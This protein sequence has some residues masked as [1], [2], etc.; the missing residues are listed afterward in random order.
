MAEG[1]L[2]VVVRVDRLKQDGGQDLGRSLGTAIR[3]DAD[4]ARVQAPRALEGLELPVLPVDQAAQL[5]HGEQ[6]RH[7]VGGLRGTSRDAA[8]IDQ[9]GVAGVA[10]EQRLHLRGRAGAEARDPQHAGTVDLFEVRLQ[11]LVLFQGQAHVDAV[12]APHQLQVQFGTD[13]AGELTP[14]LPQRHRA[15]RA[16]VDTGDDVAALQTGGLGRAA[17]VDRDHIGGAALLEHEDAR[18]PAAHITRR[19]VRLDFARRYVDREGIEGIRHAIH[20]ARRQAASVG[21]LDVRAAD[22]P[23]YL[24][25]QREVLVDRVPSAVFCVV[26]GAQ[27]GAAGETKD[28]EQGQADDSQPAAADPVAAMLPRPPPAFRVHRSVRRPRRLPRPR[29]PGCPAR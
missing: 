11:R 10:V 14:Q 28:Q 29:P 9:Q 24:L 4:V 13:R 15:G 2:A 8:D 1:R 20:G 23:K 6:T 22:Q 16:T 18:M 21:R 3:Q 17:A 26:A 25:P 27:P 7:R 12:A 5:A 19:P